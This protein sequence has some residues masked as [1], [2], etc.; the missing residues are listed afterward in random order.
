V[1]IDFERRSVRKNGEPVSLA[2]REL[3]LLRYLIDRRGK[4]VS[5]ED[6]SEG[7]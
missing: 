4:V 3:D 6:L 5:R 1:E 2:A 7:V